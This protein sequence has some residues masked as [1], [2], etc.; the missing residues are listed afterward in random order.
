VVNN[1]ASADVGRMSTRSTSWVQ[2]T[3]E[4]SAAEIISAALYRA[5]HSHVRPSGESAR[6]IE[7]TGLMPIA[8]LK[9]RIRRRN[10]AVPHLGGFLNRSRVSTGPRLCARGNSCAFVLIVYPLPGPR[11]RSASCDDS[12]KSTQVSLRHGQPTKIRAEIRGQQKDATV[13]TAC[14]DQG[15]AY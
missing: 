2:H 12:R 3:K 13:I 7:A 1:S 8:S 5:Q 6:F 15:F 9:R 14:V 11:V 4:K 10:P